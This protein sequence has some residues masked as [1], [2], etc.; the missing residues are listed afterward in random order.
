MKMND[1]ERFEQIFLSQVTRPGADKLLEWLKSTDFFTAPAS[2]RFHGAYPGG[3]VKHSLNV[4]YALLG[5][6][7]LRGLYSP[8]TQAIVAL[9][10]DVCKANYYAGEYPDYT[11]KDQMPMGHGEKSVYLVMKRMELTDDEALA[12]RWHMGAYDDAF[13]GGSR[14]LNAAMERT[15]LV[16]ELHYADMIATQ[17]EKHEEVL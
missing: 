5:N 11:V 9:L 13:R 15:P 16:L 10:H 6:F 1:A 4:Y 17:R 2:T 7:N 8:Q 14:A 12:I 3:L